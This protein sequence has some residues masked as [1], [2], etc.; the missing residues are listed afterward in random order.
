MNNYNY[1]G[2]QNFIFENYKLPLITD[3]NNEVHV[4][5]LE[6][7]YIDGELFRYTDV[8]ADKVHKQIME[9]LADK[10]SDDVVDR[11]LSQIAENKKK[12]E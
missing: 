5:E 1:I 2:L 3:G 9:K 4:K 12:N 7:R 11:I 10:I 6:T 8:L